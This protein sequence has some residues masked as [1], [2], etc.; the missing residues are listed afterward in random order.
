MDGRETRAQDLAEGMAR[1]ESEQFRFDA[2]D[3]LSARERGGTTGTRIDQQTA[4]LSD[5]VEI[6]NRSFST[7]DPERQHRR[8]RPRGA[9]RSRRRR[10]IIRFRRR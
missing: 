5:A 10:R 8:R 1:E 3:F 2:R 6:F 4:A 7:T 9:A